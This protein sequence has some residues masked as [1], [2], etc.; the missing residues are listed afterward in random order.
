[1]NFRCETC[2]KSHDISELCLGAREPIYWNY[3]L[4]PDAEG[5]ELTDDLCVIDGENFFIRCCLEIPILDTAESFEWGVWAS[6]SEASFQEINDRWNDED[7]IEIGP[8]FGWFSTELPGYPD[9]VNL[10]CMIHQ[11]PPGLR[12]LLEL[13]DCD[14]PLARHFHDGIPSDALVQIVE[15]LIHR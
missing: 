1:M 8:H 7:R 3:D 11:R 6:L 4:H 5:C 12:P 15:P 2:N 9:T 10:K 13:E 14:H